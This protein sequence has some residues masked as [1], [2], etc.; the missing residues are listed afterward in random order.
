MLQTEQ[1]KTTTL[2][3]G[4]QCDSVLLTTNADLDQGTVS[5]INLGMSLEQAH[6][7]KTAVCNLL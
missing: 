6:N 1:L 5:L 4:T 7:I 3:A 2:N